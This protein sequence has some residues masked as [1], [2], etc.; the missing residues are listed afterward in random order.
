MY[1]VHIY[2][3]AHGAV[4]WIVFQIVGGLITNDLNYFV[5]IG[6]FFLKRIPVNTITF[7]LFS[8]FVGFL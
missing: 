7:S 1:S 2:V 6:N 5:L 3:E 4:F 8:I